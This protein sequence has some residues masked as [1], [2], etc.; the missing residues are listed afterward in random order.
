MY[1]SQSQWA[2]SLYE[3]ALE[4]F[5]RHISNIFIFSKG[6]VWLLNLAMLTDVRFTG[7]V[8]ETRYSVPNSK[9]YLRFFHL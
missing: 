2:Q 9:Y 3:V 8:R 5:L 4:L 6:R 1:F 7:E